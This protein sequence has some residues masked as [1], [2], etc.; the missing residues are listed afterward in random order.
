MRSF[1]IR[2]FKKSK[3]YP[4]QT[5]YLLSKGRNTGRPSLMPNT[6]CFAFTCK[7]DRVP[8]YYAL[9]SMLWQSGH[10]RSRLIGSVIPFI[11]IGDI[12]ELIEQVAKSPTCFDKQIS[13]AHKLDSLEYNL[14]RQLIL[15][16]QLRCHLR[17]QLLHPE[18]IHTSC[19]SNSLFNGSLNKITEQNNHNT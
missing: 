6:N 8:Y 10:F 13:I 5:F 11:R 15:I 4:S 14:S 19:S 3:H 1:T 17:D 9:I 18:I 2:H 12:T 16:K 7:C